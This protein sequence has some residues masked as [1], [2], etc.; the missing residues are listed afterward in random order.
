MERKER[1]YAHI[2]TVAFWTFVVAEVDVAYRNDVPVLQ[3]ML[4]DPFRINKDA[5]FASP[6]DDTCLVTISLDH[7][8]PAADVSRVELNVV[9]RGPANRQSVL[10]QREAQQLVSDLAQQDACYAL[11]GSVGRGR[12]IVRFVEENGEVVRMITGDSYSDRVRE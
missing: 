9:V 4:G 2:S 8:M 10:E 11:V 6:V 1:D 7:G 5:I 3:K 12:E